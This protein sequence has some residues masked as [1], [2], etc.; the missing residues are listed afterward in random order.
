MSDKTYSEDEVAAKVAAAVKPLED[1]IAA[2]EAQ[3]AD[4]EIE[5]KIAEAVDPLKE[6]VA[7]LQKDLDIKTAEA[8]AAK[9]EIDDV[10]A[11]LADEQAKAE[12]AEA[13]EERKG[14]RMA[15]VKEHTNFSDEHVAA[16]IDRWADM[17]DAEFAG[18]IEDLK[19]AGVKP[20]GESKIPSTRLSTAR[21]I[22]SEDEAPASGLRRLRAAGVDARRVI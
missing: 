14:N 9:Q 8:E 10:N 13:R 20:S 17:E 7:Q 21:E 18:F 6:Q 11:Y 19:A 2:F 22:A 1:K 12:E 16:N 5:A 4:A 3:D 15:Q